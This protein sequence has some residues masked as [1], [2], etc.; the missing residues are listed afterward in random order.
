MVLVEAFEV[1]VLTEQVNSMLTGSRLQDWTSR[2]VDPVVFGPSDLEMGR[3]LWVVL[4][5]SMC[6]GSSMVS[7]TGVSGV[8]K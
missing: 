2:V 3:L 7:I 8:R 4:S 6:E 1:C 5:L